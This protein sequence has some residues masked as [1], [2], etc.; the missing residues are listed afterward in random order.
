MSERGPPV[1]LARQHS[2]RSRR[3][4]ALAVA[5]MVSAVAGVNS[6]AVAATVAQQ[7]GALP[8]IQPFDGETTSLSQFAS[9]WSAFQFSKELEKGRDTAT[10]W[11]SAWAYPNVNAAYYSA[12]SYTAAS[13]GA[14]A[15]VTLAVSPEA[16]GRYFSL[17][18]DARDQLGG[19]R[20][21]YELRFT[22]TTEETYTVALIKWVEDTETL[23]DSQRGVTFNE[24]DELAI[25][26]E[27]E[28][29]S[30]WTS[31][32]AGF[33]Q[34][35]SASDTAFDSGNVGLSSNSNFAY[36]TDFRAGQLAPAAPTLT[37]TSPASPSD[38][39]EP[40]AIGTAPPG[41]TVRLYTNATCSGSPAASGSAAAFA[42]PGLQ[43]SVAEDTTTSLYAT[44][45]DN[46][47]NVSDCSGAIA[48]THDSTIGIATALAGLTQLDAF[49]SA[50]NPLSGGGNW[51]QLAWASNTGQVAGRGTSGGWG[52]SNGYP[53]LS[54]AYWSSGGI[55]DAGSGVA[56]GGTLSVGAELANRWFSVWLDMTEPSST[57][58]GYELRFTYAGEEE[59][60]DLYDATLTR[61][62]A[63]AST[64][65]EREREV[66]LAP[67]SSFA[68]VDKGS[69]VHAWIDA[70]AGFSLL[71]SASD[72]T[73]S[74][75]YVG[76]EG[77]GNITRVREFRAGAL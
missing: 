32:G 76:L 25:V 13:G 9:R 17:W 65:L 77:A 68:L 4:V 74:R 71:L 27:G 10:G 46:L 61:W 58:S 23:L 72:A 29:V 24:G 53:V 59:G 62:V 42:S 33:A 8:T 14:A 60:E 63:G 21:G 34:L 52:P 28:A 49:S 45:T 64:L 43:V 36:V 3:V 55:A 26:D 39:A 6:N 35:L 57:R 70:G 22:W 40:L 2:R 69:A 15:A 48:Y 12:G 67:E 44:A 19:L 75:G 73:F 47:D 38:D 18:L 11:T 56:V 37:S 7:L 50:E 66:T 31:T 54:G 41:T 30:A 20:S 51:T 16:R 1:A 5:L